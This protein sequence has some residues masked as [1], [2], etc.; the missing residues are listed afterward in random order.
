MPRIIT[1]VCTARPIHLGVI[2]GITT[3]NWS[4]GPWVKGKEQK[5]AR[6]GVLICG[7]DPVATDVVG[8]RVMGFENVRAPRGTVPFGPGDNHLVMAE[9]AGLGTCEASRIDVV[10]EPIAKVRSREFPA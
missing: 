7:F 2:D 5:I 1:D 6:P 4:E 10:G 9:R 3:L 8:T